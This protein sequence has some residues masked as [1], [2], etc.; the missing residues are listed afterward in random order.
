MKRLA[1]VLAGLGAGGT[2]FT[3]KTFWPLPLIDLR[4]K[5]V[6]VTGGS[7]GLGLAVAREFGARGAIVVICARREAELER[8]VSDLRSHGVVA[9]S[10]V[11]DV[12]EREQVQGMV[13]DVTRSLDGVDVLVNNAGVIKVGPALAMDHSYFT[14][15]MNAMFFGMLNT[16][17]AVLPQMRG[18]GRGSIV[19]VTSIGGKV[20]V[21]HLLPYC[22]AKFA[23]VALSEGLGVELANSG[24]RVTT[25]VPGLMRTGSHL[26]AEFKGKQQAEYGW[27]AASAATPVVS[28]SAERAARSIVRATVYGTR[29]KILSVPAEALA[30]VQGM[31]PGLSR[32]VLDLANRMLPESGESGAAR[33]GKDLEAEFRS[34]VWKAMTRLGQRAAVGL[35]E[36]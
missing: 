25:I 11:C 18:R 31:T 15:A 30:R 12:S 9:H 36:I 14:Q 23:A 10:F 27:F 28:I 35:N 16:T 8:A 1:A 17:L 24:I 4:G 26:N 3:V 32:A 19:N 33:V 6:M 34:G 22:C 7:R 29:E 2:Y 21:P 13:E 20:T 5:V